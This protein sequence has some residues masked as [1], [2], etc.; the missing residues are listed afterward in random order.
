MQPSNRLLS[1]DVF[2]GITVTLMILVNSPGNQTAYRWLSHSTWQGCTMADIVFPFFL[3]IVGVSLVFAIQK[4]LAQHQPV[5]E[6]FLTIMWR[7]LIIFFLGLSLNAFPYHYAWETLRIYG[8]LQR[9]AICYFIAATLFLTTRIQTQIWITLSILIGYWIIL[10]FIPVPGFGVNDLTLHGNLVGYIDRSFLAEGHLYE[11]I[12]DPEGLL[13]TVPAIATTLLGNITGWLL[14][15]DI[16]KTKKCLFMLTTGLFTLMLGW[17]WGYYFPIN[18]NLWTSSFV[19]WTAG[20][21]LLLLALCY[22]LIEIK[23]YKQWSKPFEIFGLNAIAAYFLHIFFLK[24]QAMIFITKTDG[25]EENLRLF[26]TEHL[27][28]WTNDKNAS[29]LYAICYVLLW[30]FIF[31]ILYRKK[32]SIKI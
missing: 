3:F 4:H 20:L 18:K 12:F 29:L 14:M 27:F 10:T 22:W 9:I 26:M 21:G 11:K 31:S 24:I 25:T 23:N 17:L 7:S 13:S 15:I 32:I 16:N 8:V 1:L 2:R 28:G 19:L 30:L 5:R 6:I